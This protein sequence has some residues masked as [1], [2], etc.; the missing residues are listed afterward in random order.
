MRSD[1]SHD[2][3][4][5]V[6]PVCGMS[7]DADSPIWLEHEAPRGASAAR[8][9]AR[10]SRPIPIATRRRGGACCGGGHHH[11]RPAPSP[12]PDGQRPPRTLG[13]PAGRSGAATARDP[14]CGMDVAAD[15]PVAAE[16]EGR[17]HRFLQPGLPHAVP[18]RPR[19]YSPAG[20]SSSSCRSSAMSALPCRW[21]TPKWPARTSPSAAAG[22]A[23]GLGTESTETTECTGGRAR[24]GLAPQGR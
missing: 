19:R 8:A 1:D 7:V 17:T 16:H 21:R 15:A 10:S 12:R 11:P 5:A 20:R 22:T 14:V 2:D 9:A 3:Q 4:R 6:D 24:R 18:G 23:S 13:T